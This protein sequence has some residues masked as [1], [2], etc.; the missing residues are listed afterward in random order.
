LLGAGQYARLSAKTSSAPHPRPPETRDQKHTEVRNCP[1]S[2]LALVWRT[3]NDSDNPQLE[4]LDHSPH[5]KPQPKPRVTKV[6]ARLHQDRTKCEHNK[7][8]ARIRSPIP[9][10]E[11]VRS[12]RRPLK[13]HEN[14]IFISRSYSWFVRCRMRFVKNSFRLGEPTHIVS[15]LMKWG[16]ASPRRWEEVAAGLATPFRREARGESP[17]GRPRFDFSSSGV[18]WTALRM[19]APCVN[20]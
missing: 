19:R 15:P 17:R 6:P 1:R 3:P 14:I 9:K 13:R 10:T 5:P 18:R 11:A 20:S 16:C 7:S 2:R 12:R 4:N 8:L